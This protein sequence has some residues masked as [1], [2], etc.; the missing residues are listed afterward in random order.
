MT[1]IQV[2]VRSQNKRKIVYHNSTS[3]MRPIGNGRWGIFVGEE[4]MGEYDT[5]SEA[6]KGMDKIEDMHNKEYRNGVV[7]CRLND[8]R[9]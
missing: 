5:E 7:M 9:V 6:L 3:E 8:E 4:M 1:P 2:V